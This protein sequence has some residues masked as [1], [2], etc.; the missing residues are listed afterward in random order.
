MITRGSRIFFA[1]A[2]VGLAAAILY[3]IITNGLSPGAGGVIHLITG[4]HAMSA[5]L[6]PITLGYKGGVGDHFGYTLLLGFAAS[7]G[8][9]GGVTSAF[10][11]GDPESL[12]ELSPTGEVPVITAVPDLS[13]WPIVGAF[14]AAIAVTGLAV[15]SLVFSIGIVVIAIATVEWTVKAWSEQATGDT[16]V[17]QIVRAR[18][19]HPFELPIAAILVVAGL[20]FCFSRVL[21]MSSKD[22]SIVWAIVLAVAILA[23][24]TLVSAPKRMR[25][26]LVVG[27]LLVA[28]LAIIGLGIWGAARGERTFGK[29]EQA[30][31]NSVSIGALGETSS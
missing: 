29:S 10:R 6:G 11:D 31:A 9:M 5:L 13:P 4:D 17:N 3:A 2:L 24:G 20:V 23:L 28:G 7:C 12:A 18:L 8:L 22:G 1:Y 16:E 14:G 19:M 27:I 26:S 30:S 15:G 25:R 21:L